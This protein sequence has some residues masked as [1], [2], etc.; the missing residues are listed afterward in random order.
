MIDH[1]FQIAVWFDLA[2]VLL[3]AITGA[4]AGLG[5]RYDLVGVTV[6]ALV[7]ALA[8]G[9]LRD[10][11]LQRGAPA[12]LTDARYLLSGLVGAGAVAVFRGHLH[13]L[14]LVILL[15]DALGLGIYGIVGTQKALAAGLPVVA[16]L[17]IGTVNA[18]GGS[19]V[20]DV[21]VR[22]EPLVF[23]PGEW[24]ALSALTGCAV[25]VMLAMVIGLPTQRSAFVAVAFAFSTRLLSIRLGWRTEP[26]GGSDEDS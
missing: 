26:L 13:R 20:R 22:E 3:F 21:L 14:R 17:L 2:A 18:V 4:L 19:M 1:P 23:K 10:I 16:A 5:K 8:G 9:I 24:Y 12:A 15:V 25:F 6:L 7:T 11:F